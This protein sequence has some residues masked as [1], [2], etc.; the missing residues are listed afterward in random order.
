[1]KTADRYLLE[2]AEQVSH[3]IVTREWI[4]DF[5]RF[6]IASQ[7]KYLAANKRVQAATFGPVREWTDYGTKDKRLRDVSFTAGA[8]T[9]SFIPVPA[10]YTAFYPEQVQ[11]PW[12]SL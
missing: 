9:M 8:I 4:D 6:M 12:K 3:C 10:E 1:M 11:L 2:I 5:R 7:E